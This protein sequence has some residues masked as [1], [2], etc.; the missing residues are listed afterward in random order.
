M[1]MLLLFYPFL[2]QIGKEAVGNEIVEIVGELD[3]DTFVGGTT[4]PG[5][6]THNIVALGL[7]S[8]LMETVYK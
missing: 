7:R 1:G 6:L 8:L 2:A 4:K 5:E 3:A